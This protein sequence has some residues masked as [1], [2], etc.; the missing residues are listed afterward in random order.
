MSPRL[1]KPGI[2]GLQLLDAH[3]SKA[4][5]PEGALHV[6][7]R[8]HDEGG[9][10]CPIAPSTVARVVQEA[11]EWLIAQL[12]AGRDFTAADVAAANDTLRALTA[13]DPSEVP[14]MPSQS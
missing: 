4:G 14:Q 9:L 7:L 11:G 13:P 1:Y 8:I 12:E 6:F 10:P 5:L 2:F 3:C